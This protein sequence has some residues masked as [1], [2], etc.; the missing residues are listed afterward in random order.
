MAF[1]V[2]R[3]SDT[4]NPWKVQYWYAPEV[5]FIIK[6]QTFRDAD[7]A[8]A[9]HVTDS[10]CFFTEPP[11]GWKGSHAFDPRWPR[12]QTLETGFQGVAVGPVG[13]RL[14]TGSTD[15]PDAI[16]LH[17]EDDWSAEQRASFY[18]V[19]TGSLSCSDWRMVERPLEQSQIQ[20]YCERGPDDP[21]T[22]TFTTTRTH[23]GQCSVEVGPAP[24]YEWVGEPFCF[25]GGANLYLS[26]STK[27]DHLNAF[28]IPDRGEW[29]QYWFHLGPTYET[30]CDA[31]IINGNVIS[32]CVDYRQGD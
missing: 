31:I 1:R 4:D 22:T 23:R 5:G 17:F 30:D 11:P 32:E 8:I 6:I 28:T 19:D 3:T 18:P 9:M 26:T 2:T 20:H 24:D 15:N 12:L 16:P 7:N 10:H 14:F 13:T 21:P 27:L 25:H 29:A